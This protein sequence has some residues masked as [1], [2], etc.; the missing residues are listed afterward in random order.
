MPGFMIQGGDPKSK[1]M[2]LAAQWG[3]GGNTD[4][5]GKEINV[6]GEVGKDLSHTRGVISMANSGSPDSASSQFFIMH[7]DST[8]LDGGYSAFGHVVAGIKHVDEI[9]ATGPTDPSLN[10]SV[11]PEEAIVLKKA[12]IVKWPV[13]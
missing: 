2:A 7:E 4:E 8:F 6:P 9:V 11:K 12:T 10:G 13:K 3:T 1:D 5:T